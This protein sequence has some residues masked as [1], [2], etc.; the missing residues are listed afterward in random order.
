MFIRVPPTAVPY[1][2]YAGPGR[3]RRLALALFG[4]VVLLVSPMAVVAAYGERLPGR[5]YV[6]NWPLDPGGYEP[7]WDWWTSQPLYGWALYLEIGML[8]A[9]L[10]SWRLPQVQ[11]VL[12]QS[13]FL[14]GAAVGLSTAVGLLAM[15]DAPSVAKPP[16]LFAVE[17]VIAVVS[18]AFG[19]AAVGPLPREP[20]TTLLPPAYAPTMPLTPYQRAIFT[21]S[22]WSVRTL[23]MA[24]TATT[25]VASIYLNRLA[26]GDDTTL[27]S[28]GGLYAAVGVVCWPALW[29][30]QAYTRLQIDGSGVT[31]RVPLLPMLSRTVPYARI[32]FAKAKRTPPKGRYKL[33]DTDSGWGR[34]TGKGP[35]LVLALA[36]N[37]SFVYSTREA[38]TAARL[39]NGWLF[40]Q[41]GGETTAC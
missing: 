2:D 25:L 13:G 15:V 23:M 40:R 34:V 1:E 38:E 37:R 32:R 33:S 6:F 26:N 7:S 28:F 27:L 17:V 22:A 14:F 16:W 8:I 29:A 9:F 3:L 35:V 11:R 36:D 30:A 5:V 39:V 24:A 4:P 18:V 12:V 19:R 10:S 31:V 20:E 41:R 21:T